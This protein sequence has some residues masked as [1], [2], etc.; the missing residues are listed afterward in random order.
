MVYSMVPDD[1]SVDI[2]SM[3]Q[4]PKKVPNPM[5]W[6]PMARSTENVISFPMVG[7]MVHVPWHV[8]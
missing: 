8:P 7:P 3:G 5:P 4:S 2:S 6:S 1:D